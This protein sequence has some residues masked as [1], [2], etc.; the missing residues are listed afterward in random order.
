[1]LKSKALWA[2]ILGFGALHLLLAY[3]LPLVEDETYYAL[4]ATV[5]SAGYYDHPP[6][7]AWWIA[8]GQAVVGPGPLGVRVMSVL[9]GSAITLLIWRIA[10]IYA[11]D[12]RVALRAAVWGQ[13]MLPF[14]VFGFAAT[15]DAPS[16]LF[17]TATIWALAE[18]G[19]Q[20]NA[21]WFLLVGLFAGLGVL[22]KFTDLFAGLG[23][24]IWL[25]A[26]RE[27][28][29]W[30]R[31]W[32]VWAGAVIGVAVLLP[33]AWWNAAHDWV[34]LERQFGRIAEVRAFSATDYGAYWLS[35]VVLVTPVLF[36]L[37][38]RSLRSDKVPGVLIWIS[39]PV[40]L[41][42]AYYA[43]QSSAGG[44]WLVPVFPTLAV[45]AALAARRDWATRLATPTGLGLAALVLVL[46]FWPG[47]VIIPGQNPFNQ[48]RGWGRVTRDI[49][50]LAADQGAVWIATDAYGLT[51]QL[52]WYLSRDLPVWSVTQ[53]KRYLFR[54]PMP[55]ALC[56]AKGVFI[57]RTDFAG[58]IPYFVNSKPLE[59][60]VR[61]QGGRVLM[62]YQAAL[63]SQPLASFVAACGPR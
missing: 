37:V 55:Q 51:G 52:T 14:A 29:G 7:V 17:W 49:Q 32:Q 11:D 30:L 19:R 59:H 48:G 40:I 36:W 50:A 13:V 63:V 20:R 28:R 15:P 26:S 31:H 33:F 18:A 53:P 8:A 27:G 58:S 23:L 4:W 62:T 56:Q 54:G 16:V 24:V 9:A 41:Y 35:V 43:T 34:G 6:M 1:M 25:L 57:S 45:M 39:A 3:A 22:S 10:M 61:H 12:A 44:Q 2:L 5:P 21:A 42:L 46:G 38:L 60:I 47:R